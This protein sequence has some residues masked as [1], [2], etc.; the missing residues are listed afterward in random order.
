MARTYREIAIEEMLRTV[1]EAMSGVIE[2]W[3]D[4]PAPMKEAIEQFRGQLGVAIDSVDLLEGHSIDKST[5]L[6]TRK[7]LPDVLLH[8]IRVFLARL[9]LYNV[10]AERRANVVMLAKLATLMKIPVITTAS[11]PNGTNGPL[12]PEIHQNAPHAVYVPRKGE[13][14]AWDNEDSVNKYV[15]PASRLSRPKLSI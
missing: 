9:D 5:K 4:L 8:G 7:A 6:T 10:G 3:G 1:E 12:M 15:G 11:E 13:V 14:N 2:W